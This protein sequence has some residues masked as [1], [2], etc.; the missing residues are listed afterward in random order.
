MYKTPWNSGGE[1]VSGRGIGMEAVRL[2][3]RIN[4]TGKAPMVRGIET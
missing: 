4:S 2:G 1:R 3:K